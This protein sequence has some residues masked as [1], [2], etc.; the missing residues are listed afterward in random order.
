MLLPFSSIFYHVLH[1]NI[2]I[3]ILISISFS[4]LLSELPCEL[5]HSLLLYNI[6]ILLHVYRSVLLY[7]WISQEKILKIIFC[8][9]ISVKVLQNSKM[10]WVRNQPSWFQSSIPV[11][12]AFRCNTTMLWKYLLHLIGVSFQRWN[13]SI[14]FL[15]CLNDWNRN[16]IFPSKVFSIPLLARTSYLKDFFLINSCGIKINWWTALW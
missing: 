2:L 11:C 9:V 13:P 14:S 8:A 3:Y 15:I 1:L 5:L 7:E 12:Q 10:R 16:F 6:W 4:R